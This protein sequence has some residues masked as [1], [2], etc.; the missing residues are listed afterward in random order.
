MESSPS[1]PPNSPK[2]EDNNQPTFEQLLD[3]LEVKNDDPPNTTPE[4]NVDAEQTDK[5]I[6]LQEAVELYLSKNK[7]RILIG[8]P[9]FGGQVYSGYFQSMCDLV[10]KLTVLKIP[11]DILNIGNES[12]VTRARNGIVA[13][14]L[15]NDDFSH[16]IFI[17]ADITF[18]W[19]G[20]IKLLLSDRDVCGACYPKKNINWEKV[21]NQVKKNPSIDN[22]M[23]L[24]KSLDYV[25]NPV[26]FKDEQN[27][28]VARMENGFV[29]V[30]DVATG[31]MM[32]KRNV[33]TAMKLKYPELQYKNNVAGYHN[34]QTAD[35]FYTFFDTAID[36][37][38]KV[39]LSEDYLFCKRWRELGG[40][41][42]LDLD[43]N[44]NHTGSMDY[45]GSLFLNI[46]EMDDLNADTVATHNTILPN[47]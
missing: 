37:D 19:I 16:L 21:K 5:Q 28:T 3:N 38:S 12:L 46:N 23:L 8:T 20:V 36:P 22:K 34:E 31:F 40:D 6:S 11:Y 18:P 32:I 30:K 26:Y 47:E 7:V 25:F 27:N 14:F 43:T 10:Q 1:N 45:V 33:F 44:L 42:W 15:G 2:Q 41:L 4:P 39:Y 24:A 9:C 29:K 35:N 17:D 13:K